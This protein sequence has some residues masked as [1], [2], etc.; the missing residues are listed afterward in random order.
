MTTQC[1]AQVLGQ[2]MI[3]DQHFENIAEDTHRRQ[4]NYC[5][6]YYNFPN[7]EIWKTSNLKDGA[8]RI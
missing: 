7:L 8:T 5:V 4:K 1:P 2:S 6:Y 3:Y